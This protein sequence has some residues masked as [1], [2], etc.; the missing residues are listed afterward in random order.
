MRFLGPLLLMAL[1]TNCLALVTYD[2][3]EGMFDQIF[4]PICNDCHTSDFSSDQDG[5]SNVTTVDPHVDREGAAPFINFNTYVQSQITYTAGTYSGTNAVRGQLYVAADGMPP[6]YD[7]LFVGTKSSGQINSNSPYTALTTNQKNLFATWITDGALENAAPSTANAIP[8]LVTKTSATLNATLAENGSETTVVFRHATTGTPLSDP[9]LNIAVTSPTGTGGGLAKSIST[10]VSSLLCGTSYHYKIFATNGIG[11][12]NSGTPQTYSTLNCSAP[13][14]DEGTSV[15]RSISV[16]ENPNA[17]SLTLNAS[18]TDGTS[19]LSWSI[20]SVPVNAG[21]ASVTSGTGASQV[22]N[23]NPPNASYSGTDQFVVTV[24]DDTPGTQLTDSITVNVSIGLE[25]PVMSGLSTVTMSEDSSPTPFSLTLSAT[26]VDTTDSLLSWDILTPAS[27]G[28]AVATGTGASKAIT[29]TPNAHINGNAADSFTVRVRD[30]QLNDDTI[31]VSVNITAVNDTPSA[32]VDNL[33]VEANSTGNT[34][35]VLTNDTDVDAGD[36]KRIISVGTPSNGGS[37]SINN[38]GSTD[39]TLNYTPLNGSQTPESFTYTMQDTDGL[40][41]S[42]TV[43][44]SFLDTDSDGLADPFDN[45]PLVSNLDQ[46]DTDVDGL[47]DVCDNDPTASGILDTFIVFNVNQNAIDGSILF[48]DDGD[49]TVTADLDSTTGAGVLT[50]DWSQTDAELIAAQVSLNNNTFVFD[51]S[52][53][54]LGTYIIDVTIDDDGSTTHNTK[55]IN[56]FAN[57]LPVL[58]TTN[59]DGEGADDLTE[60]YGDSDNDGI[61]NFRDDAGE[62]ENELSVNSNIGNS[63]VIK[64]ETG[65]KLSIGDIALSSGIFAAAITEET[66]AQYA[67]QGQPV[68][69]AVDNSYSGISEIFDFII[70]DITQAGGTAKVVLPL[71]SSIRP[72]SIYRKYTVTNG[73]QD[74]VIDNNNNISTASTTAGICPSPGS[75]EYTTGLNAFE[76]CIQLTLQDGGP[77]DSDGEINGVIRD[78]GVLAL[79]SNLATEEDDPCDQAVYNS[80]ADK[81]GGIGTLH[82]LWILIITAIGFY[83]KKCK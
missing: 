36:T 65:T 15:L 50:H 17:F 74:F 83:R 37:V 56:I 71:R 6:Q 42:A 58:T 62:A 51:P 11:S 27:F 28:T 48:T 4:D 2:G 47:G 30:P 76:N 22:I 46:T 38:A 49:V 66:I 25:A 45:C 79:D 21:S 77:N 80:C 26:D 8:S 60:G 44:I 43:N 41:A 16:N 31:T 73:W 12:N 23:Y 57:T 54:A 20:S 61:P 82:P 68:L 7:T 40:Q 75:I 35:T 72:N 78:P 32:T 14:I 18:D 5:D 69:N 1:S 59:T 67:N 52:S 24:T 13:S 81:S 3:D 34:L 10:N 33:T 53:L 70:S 19:N 55:M 63:V 39:N 64:S 9:G 29:Y